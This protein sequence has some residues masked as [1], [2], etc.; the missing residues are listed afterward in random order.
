MTTFEVELVLMCCA[1]VAG[2]ALMVVAVVKTVRYH[3]W[4]QQK[5]APPA[6]PWFAA[7]MLIGVAIL[8]YAFFWW[9]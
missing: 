1:F 4:G 2:L 7:S 6:V 9:G 3:G 5:L 8:A